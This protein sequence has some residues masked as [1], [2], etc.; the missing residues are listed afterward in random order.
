[1]TTNSPGFQITARDMEILSAVDAIALTARQLLTFSVTFTRPFTQLRLVQRR[2]Q[3]LVRSGL[4]Q[5]FSYAVASDGRSPHY[6]KLTRNGYRM[7]HGFDAV[8][9]GRRYFERIAEN[10]HFHTRKLGDF[11]VTLAQRC[12]QGGMQIEQL[13]R[14]NTVAIKTEQTTLYPDAAFCLRMADGRR[15]NFVVELD[16]G[17]ERVRSAKDTESIERKI[18]GYDTH[19]SRLDAFSPQ[20]YVVLFVTTRSG[21]RLRHMLSAARELMHNPQRRVFLGVCLQDFIDQARELTSPCF[22]D[23]LGRAC[24]L[25]STTAETSTTFMTSTVFPC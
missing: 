20:R 9:P 16:N 23:V 1:M 11:L 17:S 21:E 5:S 25:V 2:L 15:F 4:L 18:R 6:F 12:V 19:Q 7:L 24:S 14:E 13:A 3:V 8:L 22:Q 10:H